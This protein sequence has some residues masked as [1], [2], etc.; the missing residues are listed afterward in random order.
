[1]PHFPMFD[2]EFQYEAFP[3]LGRLPQHSKLPLQATRAD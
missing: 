2:T 1:M 3:A